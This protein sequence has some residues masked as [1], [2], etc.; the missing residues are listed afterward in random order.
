ML[1]RINPLKGVLLISSLLFIAACDKDDDEPAATLVK[2]WTVPM[3]TAN[4]NPAITGRAETAT[5]Q[6]QLYSDNSFHYHVMING[7]AGGDNITMG[8]L[9]TGDPVTNGPVILDLSPTVSGGMSTGVVQIPRQSLADSIRNGS[10]YINFHSTQAPGGLIRG[11]LDKT[12]DLVMDIPLSGDNEV[13]PVATTA[14]GLAMIRLASDK[15]LYYRINVQNL[16]ANDALTAAHFHPGA[17]GANGGVLVGLISN[18]DEFGQARNLVLTD[19]VFNAVKN[20]PV[21][22]NVHS[23]NHGPGLIRGQLR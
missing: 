15:T 3:S 9:H 19:E 11:Q 21:Y 6:L 14:T 2:E 23:T 8:H 12:L 22:V 4:E 5:A 13:P 1:K 17:A 10:V 20:D 18:A 7:L 16:E